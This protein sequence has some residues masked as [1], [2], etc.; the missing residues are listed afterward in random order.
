MLSSSGSRGSPRTSIT[1][2]HSIDGTKEE[3]AEV[4]DRSEQQAKEAQRKATLDR[5]GDIALES[6]AEDAATVAQTMQEVGLS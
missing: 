3:P 4:V 1:T 2:R 5:P 6:Q